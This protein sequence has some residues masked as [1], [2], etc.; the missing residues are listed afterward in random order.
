MTL[1]FPSHGELRVAYKPKTT[2]VEYLTMFGSVFGFWFGLSVF[3]LIGEV[4]NLWRGPHG[5]G[6]APIE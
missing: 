5:V 2:M 1:D 4:L 3:G 6:E